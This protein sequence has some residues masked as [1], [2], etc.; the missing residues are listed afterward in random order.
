MYNDRRGP[1]CTHHESIGRREYVPTLL[2][3]LYGKLVGKYTVRPMDP[4]WDTVEVESL[5]DHVK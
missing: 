1:P 5:Y 3:H 4:S 2:A